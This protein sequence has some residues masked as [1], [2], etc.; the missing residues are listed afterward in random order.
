[1]RTRVMWRGAALAI[2]VGAVALAM[3]P[4]DEHGHQHEPPK[5]GT[6]GISSEHTL[7]AEL[8]GSY[9]A[10]MT[11]WA[12]AEA[13]PV[14]FAAGAVR[15]PILGGRFLQEQLDATTA[16]TPFALQTTLGFNLGAKEGPRFELSRLSSAASPMIVERG[17]FDSPNKVFT[18]TGEYATDGLNVKSRS[19]LRLDSSEMQVLDVF[20]AFTGIDPQHEGVNVPEFKA[21]SV[22]YTRRR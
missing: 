20:V 3:Q 12:S 14:E 21:Y 5:A 13:K 6:V 1:M 11:V 19:V 18:F 17:K 15:R 8:A 16:P 22:E 10:K 7:L 2:V 9:D 4:V